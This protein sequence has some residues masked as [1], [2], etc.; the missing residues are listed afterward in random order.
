MLREIDRLKK[1]FLAVSALVE[2]NLHEAVQAVVERDRDRARR[3][4]EKDLEI[5]RAEVAVEEECLKLLALYQPVAHD[6]RYIIA[7]LKINHDLERIGDQAVNIAERA[8]ILAEH[9]GNGGDFGIGGMAARVQAMLNRSL[10]A[11]I[12]C[13]LEAARHVWLAEDDAVDEENRQRVARLEEEIAR[14]PDRVR[15]LLAYLTVSRILERIADHATN[16]AKDAIYMIEGEIVRH[17]S[18]QFRPPPNTPG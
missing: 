5:D 16:I 18:R 8:V 6:L 17:R 12:R 11:L 1:L 13:D 14:R 15:P 4:I 9:N 10:D 7:I 3:A 2:E